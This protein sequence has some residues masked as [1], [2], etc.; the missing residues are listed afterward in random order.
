MSLEFFRNMMKST[1]DNATALKNFQ[2]DKD[3]D[4]PTTE[5]D[6]K[7]EGEQVIEPAKKKDVLPTTSE[8]E[9]EKRVEAEKTQEKIDESSDETEKDLDKRLSEID[10]VIDRYS[11]QVLSTGK[12]I[13]ESSKDINLPALDLGAVT[14]KQM[15]TELTKPSRSRDRVSLLYDELKKYNLI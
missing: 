12:K 1:K 10:K 4:Y 14:Q 6:Y 3:Y 9:E 7:L 11:G 5:S 15:V 8:E 13:D 2:E